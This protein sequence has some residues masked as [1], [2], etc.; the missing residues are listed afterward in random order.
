MTSLEWNEEP[1]L[2][3]FAGVLQV[4]PED[5]WEGPGPLLD[6]AR[7]QSPGWADASPLRPTAQ[8]QDTM[9]DKTVRVKLEWFSMLFVDG[10]Y[11]YVKNDE[12]VKDA[13]ECPKSW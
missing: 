11:Q 7:R 3:P 2:Y 4:T 13:R 5:V 6:P 12:A 8:H 10:R 9:S 1:S